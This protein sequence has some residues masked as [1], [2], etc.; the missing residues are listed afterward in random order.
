M[1]TANYL[2]LGNDALLAALASDAERWSAFM[3]WEIAACAE[4]GALD[5]GTH[6]I[7]VAR[8]PSYDAAI[9]HFEPYSI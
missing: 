5:G 2:S 4:P 3:A 8:R 6:M 7:A 9:S 1:W